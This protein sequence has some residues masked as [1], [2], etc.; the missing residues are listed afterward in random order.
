LW[1]KI[2]APLEQGFVTDIQADSGFQ[3][4]K[5]IFHFFSLGSSKKPLLALCFILE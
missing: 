3:V 4:K 5:N 2:P 1:G